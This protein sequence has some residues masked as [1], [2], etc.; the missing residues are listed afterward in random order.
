MP[1]FIEKPIVQKIVH[2]E[3]WFPGKEVEGVITNDPWIQTGNWYDRF[4]D[5]YG[6]EDIYIVIDGTKESVREGNWIVTDSKGKKSVVT[7]EWIE[8]Y[9]DLVE[10]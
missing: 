7:N 1:K 3:Q 5:G 2:A 4:S 9:Y 10:E 6:I 8:K